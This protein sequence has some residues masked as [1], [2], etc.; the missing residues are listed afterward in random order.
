M[1]IFPLGVTI[2]A[3]LTTKNPITRKKQLKVIYGEDTDECVQP[4]ANDLSRELR[5]V[6]HFVCTIFTPKT[7]KYEYA[8]EK[9]LLFLWAYITDSKIDLS[10]FILDHVFKA[11]MT[12]ISLPYGIFLIK[13]SKYFKIDLN[14]E[15]KRTPK[16]IIDEYNEKSLKRMWYFLKNN[17]WTPK[18]TKK[19][20]E[21]STSKE[22]TPSGSSSRQS[23]TK[24]SLT[25]EFKGVEMEIGCLMVQ[26]MELLQK[27]DEK[28]DNAATRLLLLERKVR[29]LKKEV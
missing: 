5:L 17:K 20:G 18:P 25:R 6:H 2:R 24:K 3:P 23:S 21:V 13:V 4:I 7:E 26:V 28:A 22:K 9:K 16:S 1:T 15:K 19:I 8:S 11:T 10:L 14:N 12:K 29:E 27:L